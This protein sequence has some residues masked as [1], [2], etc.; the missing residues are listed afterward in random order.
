MNEQ[1][2]LVVIL[3]PAHGSDVLGKRSPDGSHLEY[4]WSRKICSLL[5]DRLL[6]AGYRVEFTTTLDKEPGLTTRKR[7]AEN[8]KTDKNQTKFLISLHN[9]GAGDGSKW[10]TARGFEIYTYLRASTSAKFAKTIMEQLIRD[11]PDLKYR[12]PSPNI[13][14]K[15]ANFT[16]LSG[17]G[18]F[19]VLLEWL[20]QDNK[21]DVELLKNPEMNEKLADSLVEAIETINNNL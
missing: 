11:F 5:K 17:S 20:F 3:D 13:F 10:L 6:E 8:L 18:Y 4:K 7:F 15:E 21:E 14:N 16:V 2:K 12:I 9:N 1:R 19:A